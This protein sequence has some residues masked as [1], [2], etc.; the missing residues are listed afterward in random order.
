MSINPTVSWY[1]KRWAYTSVDTLGE[2][3]QEQLDPV[4][5]I[6]LFFWYNTPLKGLTVGAGVYDLLDQRFKFLQPYNGYHAPLPGP[7]REFLFRLQYKLN[8]KSKS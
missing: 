7:S 1:G 6:N 4:V 3:V 2:A 8:Y 5:L